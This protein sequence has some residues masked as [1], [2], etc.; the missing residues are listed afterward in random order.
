MYCR[1]ERE[2]ELSHEY[3]QRGCIYLSGVL[4]VN[5][6][7]NIGMKSEIGGEIFKVL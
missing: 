6:D 7:A 4:V 1:R 5:F 3:L 2:R